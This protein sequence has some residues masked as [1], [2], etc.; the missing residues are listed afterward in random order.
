MKRIHITALQYFF[1]C[2]ATSSLGSCGGGNAEPDTQLPTSKDEMEK[3]IDARVTEYMKGNPIACPVPGKNSTTQDA[4]QKI[5]AAEIVTTK[6][7]EAAAE[8]QKLTKEDIETLEKL[9]AAGLEKFTAGKTLEMQELPET[10]KR[11]I[12][13]VK[14]HFITTRLRTLMEAAVQPYANDTGVWWNIV[15]HIYLAAEKAV[16]APET[17]VEVAPAGF[18][19]GALQNDANNAATVFPSGGVGNVAGDTPAGRGFGDLIDNNFFAGDLQ[20][21]NQAAKEHV[22]VAAGGMKIKFTRVDATGKKIS[23]KFIISGG[24]LEVSD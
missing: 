12:V 16:D 21:G 13:E 14:N 11:L 3:L 17:E 22:K 19:F 6:N 8:F 18:D 24:K 2:V 10:M 23:P 7:K 15:K 20:I 1:T 5:N 9:H 4:I